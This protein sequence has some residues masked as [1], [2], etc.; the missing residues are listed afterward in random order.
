[1]E[2]DVER[3]DER[4]RY[5]IAVDGRPAGFADFRQE[6]STVVFP[7]TVIEASMRCQGIGGELVRHALDDVR[8]AGGSVVAQCWYVAQFIDE[9]REY[10]DLLVTPRA[11]A[12]GTV[13]TSDRQ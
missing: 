5:E 4:S 7:H 2:V 1:M 11:D 9:H 3:N 8:A 13:S 6:G 12:G 10:S